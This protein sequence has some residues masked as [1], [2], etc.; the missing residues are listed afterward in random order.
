MLLGR[1][2]NIDNF[3]LH[4]QKRQ[5]FKYKLETFNY[6]LTIEGVLNLFGKVG[7]LKD[8]EFIKYIKDMINF[9]P[10]LNDFYCYR[11]LK[12]PLEDIKKRR[13]NNELFKI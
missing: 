4:E 7:A 6:P 8:N 11:I 10:I 12:H 3:H 2:K 5:E 9:E 1:E 13:A